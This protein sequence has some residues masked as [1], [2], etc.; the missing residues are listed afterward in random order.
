MDRHP[1]EPRLRIFLCTLIALLAA[2]PPGWG[3]AQSA[4]LWEVE[5]VEWTPSAISLSINQQSFP[6]TVIAYRDKSGNWWLPAAILKD[7][8]VVVD[9][10][11]PVRQFGAESY[12]ELTR[13][14]P[15]SVVLE[16]STQT[17]SVELAPVRFQSSNLRADGAT[18]PRAVSRSSGGFLNYDFFADHSRFGFGKS[19]HAEAGLSFGAGA[20]VTSHS[21]LDQ[22]GR[23]DMLRLE[24]TYV[25]DQPQSLASWRIGDAVTRPITALGR[26]ARFG[27]L[28][29]GTNF[30]TQPGFVTAPFRM[31]SAQA[32]LPSTVELY[33]NNA[34]QSSSNVPP[35][36][37]SVIAPPAMSGDGE[38]MLRIRDLSGREEVISQ[39]FYAS[40]ALLAPGLIDFSVE[41]GAL[42]RNFGLQSDDYGEAFVSGGLRRGI[43]P[44]LTVELSGAASERRFSTASGGFTFAYPSLGVLTGA[45]AWSRDELDS[46]TALSIGIERRAKKHSVTLRTQSSEA[47]FRQLGVDTL[48][49]LRRIDSLFYGYQLAN[50][51]TLGL[52]WTR[53]GRIGSDSVDVA[54][55]S[56]TSRRTDWGS[57]VLSL[58]ETRAA[59]SSRSINLLWVIPVGAGN[60][61]SAFH[62]RSSE[63]EARTTL[64]WQKSLPSDEGYGYRLQAGVN[65]PQQASLLAQ[66]RYG[67]ARLEA[68]ESNGDTSAR[69]GFS[70]A[71]A[72]V[73]DEWFASR[74]IGGSFGVARLG[75]PNVRV[76]VDNLAAG[77][78][79]ERGVAFLPRLN[80]Y[81]RNNV[82]IEPMD[83]PLDTQIDSLGAE[84]VPA[85]RS[86]VLVE[87]QVRSVA[88]ATLNLLLDV[89]RPV[90]AGTTA[91][92]EGRET[93]DPFVVGLDGL[94]YLTG[95]RPDNQ[96][97]V[98]WG[99]DQCLVRLPYEARKGTIPY[100]GE[101]MCQPRK[102]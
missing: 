21:F 7:A 57:L 99:D 22:P 69:V 20:F 93:D 83:L 11:Q 4:G 97:I 13:L 92:F 60:S 6:Q 63:D 41:A 88:A 39:R 100:L 78:T 49:R 19:L 23:T 40:G 67:L 37:F 64:Q 45:L 8:N 48:N 94:L 74:R 102:K 76:Y 98:K 51:G 56:F 52:A 82:S 81:A 33:V 61:A 9:S 47:G 42:R 72:F 70:G 73:D 15:L 59:T 26:A 24:S 95:L 55:V 89:G 31:L 96:L 62:T 86:G 71:L 35:G 80:A 38:V 25:I 90:P 34:L 84:P 17:L 77:R 65:A 14:Q 58:N 44:N 27:G 1:L 87:F 32:A 75:I 2:L 28:Q 10:G 101:F 29:F 50:I 79:D 12:V 36:P 85:W 66:N 53:I 18:D 43:H 30:G 54:T 16:D 3:I 46:G 68:A 91:S 5:E